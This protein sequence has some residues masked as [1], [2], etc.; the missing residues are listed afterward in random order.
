MK[1][2]IEKKLRRKTNT[3]LV[4]TII[5]AKK[6]KAWLKVAHLISTPKRKQLALNLEDIDAQAKDNETIVVPGKVL[7]TGEIT[8]KIRIVGLSFST[9]A[10][11][12]LEKAKIKFSEL[13]EEIKSNPDAKDI[14]ILNKK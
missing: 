14:R 13:A 1:S 5:S 9:S 3:E 2:K 10:V 7:G 4:E 12:K 6:K 11:E 8:K